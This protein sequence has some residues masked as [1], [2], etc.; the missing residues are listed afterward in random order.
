MVDLCFIGL[1]VGFSL[2]KL[3]DSSS[4]KDFDIL[5]LGSKSTVQHC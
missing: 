3:R 1:N 5:P 2:R 4:R